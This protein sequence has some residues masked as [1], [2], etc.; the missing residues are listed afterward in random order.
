MHSAPMGDIK[1]MEVTVVPVRSR[2]SLLGPA[3]KM[4]L[5]EVNNTYS[6]A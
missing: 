3:V 4:Y 5:G 6:L 2:V 1:V